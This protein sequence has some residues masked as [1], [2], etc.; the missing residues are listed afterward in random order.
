MATHSEIIELVSLESEI[1]RHAADVAVQ[2]KEDRKP[3][4]RDLTR[5]IQSRRRSEAY[6]EDM[7]F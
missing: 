5:R 3:S 6:A 2:R 1:L 7:L 4:G